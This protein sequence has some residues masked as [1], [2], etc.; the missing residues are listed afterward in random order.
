MRLL[1]AKACMV[2]LCTCYASAVGYANPNLQ[3][4]RIAIGTIALQLAA[5]FNL[6]LW[7]IDRMVMR[8]VLSEEDLYGTPL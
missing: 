7:Q 4:G 6:L 2:L 3:I 5:T 8:M 1:Q